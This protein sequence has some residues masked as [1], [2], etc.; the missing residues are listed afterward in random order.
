MHIQG[1]P[2]SGSNQLLAGLPPTLRAELVS[3]FNN[4]LKNYREKRWGPSELDGGKFCE[5]VYSILRGHVDGNYPAKASKPSNM[6]D[7]CRALEQT[8]RAQFPRSIRIQIPRMLVA[9]YE[10]RNNRGVG[11]IGGDVDPNHMDAVCV[12]EISKWIMAELVRVFH[13]VATEEAER[14]IEGLIQRTTELI[15]EINGM[16][17]VLP[18]SLTYFEKALLIL[19]ASNSSVTDEQLVNWLE[20]SNPSRFKRNLRSRHSERLIEY[21]KDTGVVHISPMGRTIVEQEII[22]NTNINE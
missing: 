14:A 22:P 16:L 3:S 12:V 13:G 21:D 1:N 15:W 7:A 8:P 4:I 10:I 9:L 20:P 19:H 6:V 2:T 18:A 17:R 11:H 5:I